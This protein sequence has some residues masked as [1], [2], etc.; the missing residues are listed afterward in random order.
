MRNISSCE[1]L[2]IPDKVD[3]YDLSYNKNIPFTFYEKY[4]DKVNWYDLS[5][6]KNIPFTF[7]EKHLQNKKYKDK[8]SW[9]E[10]LKNPSIP[11]HF[12]KIK[13]LTIINK[14]MNKY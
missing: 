8:I 1:Q 2:G 12:N 4:L 5:Y 7:Y 11:N 13:L 10:L 9:D 14:I 3:W 6:N